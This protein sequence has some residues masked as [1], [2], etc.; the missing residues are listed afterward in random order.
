MLK[1]DCA[2]LMDTSN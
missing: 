2:M 1:C